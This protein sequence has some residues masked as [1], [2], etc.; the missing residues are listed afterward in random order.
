MKY[1]SILIKLSTI[2]FIIS[3]ISIIALYIHNPFVFELFGGE[4]EIHKLLESD[5]FTYESYVLYHMNAPSDGKADISINRINETH[6]K[7][8]INDLKKYTGV[9]VIKPDGSRTKSINSQEYINYENTQEGDYSIIGDSDMGA[10][11]LHEYNTNKGNTDIPTINNYN[12]GG[13][14]ALGYFYIDREGL[15]RTINDNEKVDVEIGWYDIDTDIIKID[16]FNGLQYDEVYTEHIEFHTSNG[17]IF[18]IKNPGNNK[19]ISIEKDEHIAM[20]HK[21][22][23]TGENQIVDCSAKCI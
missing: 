16:E 20:V 19:T 18:K 4:L 3:S 1:K 15:N 8:Q 7:L 2:V 17:D 10:S 5:G 11:K 13:P 14:S 21:N 12:L 22:S 9:Y 6:K 23:I